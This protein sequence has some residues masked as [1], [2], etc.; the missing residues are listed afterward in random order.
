MNADQGEWTVP[1]QYQDIAKLP[2]EQQKSWYNATKDK[3]KSLYDRKVWDLVDL[4]KGWQPIKGRWVFAIQFGNYVKASFV[5]KGFT[6]IFKIDYEET[7][8]PIARFETVCLVLALAALH[9]WEIKVL[10][11]KTAFLFGK[12]DEEIYMMQP[13]GFIVKKICCLWKAIYGLKQAALQWNKLLHKSLVNFDF[14]RCTSDSGIYVKF[15][16]KDIILIVI[17]IDDA[18]FLGSNKLQ[19][20][21]H[22]KK[23]M[24]KWKS[25]VL[26]K[27][28]EYL[29]MRVTRDCWKKS[30]ILDQIKYVSKVIKHFVTVFLFLLPSPHGLTISP[31]TYGYNVT[32]SPIWL[33]LTC[34]IWLPMTWTLFHF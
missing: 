23:P 32:W 26:G 8:S 18:L 2:Q 33:I 1:K 25:R 21:S 28:K 9:D 6:Q 20:L 27:A 24:Q 15:I 31:S 30:L 34:F 19:V 17:Y 7:F 4:S 13:E 22:K 10:D 12:F 5:A 3:M 14:K 16:C 29:D 11:V